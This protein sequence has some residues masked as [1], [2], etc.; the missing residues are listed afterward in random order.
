MWGGGRAEGGRRGRG[1]VGWGSVGLGVEANARAT[2]SP[3]HIRAQTASKHSTAQ[4]STAQQTASEQPLTGV[5]ALVLVLG[6]QRGDKVGV[7]AV[8]RADRLDDDLRAALVD[9][10]RRPLVLRA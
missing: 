5:A 4:H 8:F 6:Q 9:L 10:E 7:A 2:R 1:S 3:P